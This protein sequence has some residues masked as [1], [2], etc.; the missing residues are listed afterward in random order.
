MKRIIT[1]L[2]L[3]ILS[4]TSFAQP[5]Y[6]KSFELGFQ[7]GLS[8]D[9][10]YYFGI[11]MINGLRFNDIISCGIG[12][13]YGR[14]D[15]LAWKTKGYKDKEYKLGNEGSSFIPVYARFKVN[16]TKKRI[17]PF[18][19]GNL[20]YVF[21]IGDTSLTNASGI[22]GEADFGVD[23]PISEG[24]KLYFMAGVCPRLSQTFFRDYGNLNADGLVQNKETTMISF[25]IGFMF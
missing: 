16:L 2:S 21:D 25:K 11:D 20:G 24:S 4:L 9:F 12:V 22:Y 17:S 23:V 8:N 10:N 6:E 15:Y 18:L 13:G 7:K 5:K 1:L 14:G 19:V 3:V